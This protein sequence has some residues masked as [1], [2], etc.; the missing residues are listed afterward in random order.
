MDVLN[1]FLLYESVWEQFTLPFRV[2]VD[3]ADRAFLKMLNNKAMILDKAHKIK[4]IPTI[5]KE[6]GKKEIQTRIIE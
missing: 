4:F 2:A 6:E 5:G 1:F 3:S